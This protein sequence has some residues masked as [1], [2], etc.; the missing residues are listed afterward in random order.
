MGVGPLVTAYHGDGGCESCRGVGDDGCS[1]DVVGG[2]WGGG[3]GYEVLRTTGEAS[4]CRKES[5][6]QQVGGRDGDAVSG[7]WYRE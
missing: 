5:N 1:T 4:S 2:G 3:V 6:S 7:R